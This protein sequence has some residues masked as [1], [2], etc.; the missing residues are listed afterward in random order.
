MTALNQIRIQQLKQQQRSQKCKRKQNPKSNIIDCCNILV[1]ET[2]K[3]IT[4][5]QDDACVL[6]WTLNGFHILTSVSA[7]LATVISR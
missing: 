5:T 7:F 3:Q 4:S 6:V 1:S 2:R